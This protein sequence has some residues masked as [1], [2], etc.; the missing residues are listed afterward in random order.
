MAKH[1]CA[2]LRCAQ[3]D[4]DACILFAGAKHPTRKTDKIPLLLNNNFLVSHLAYYG[5]NWD[6][7]P[8]KPGLS[9]NQYVNKAG[10]SDIF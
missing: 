3:R 5:S 6:P 2:N 8:A 9:T 10:S 1:L 7:A 4:L